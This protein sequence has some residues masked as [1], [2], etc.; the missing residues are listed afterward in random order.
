M[1]TTGERIK[2][3]RISAGM[4][5]TELAN[6]IGVK[7]SAVHKYE[8]GIVVNLKREVIDNLAKALN[9]KPSYLLCVEEKSPAISDEGMSEDKKY[10]IDWIR[11]AP[12]NEVAK[13]RL[14]VDQVIGARGK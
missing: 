3:A 8:S 2:A 11:S 12:E 4:T 5:Q 10:L 13:L 6:K 1:S 14:I 9:V 7:Y